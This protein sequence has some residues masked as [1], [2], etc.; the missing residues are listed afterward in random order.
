MTLA[1]RALLPPPWVSIW[2]GVPFFPMD[3][4]S[5]AVLA[6]GQILIPTTEALSRVFRFLIRVKMAVH[7]DS[8]SS[9]FAEGSGSKKPK[10]LDDL[11]PIL[12]IDEDEIAEM[13]LP[14]RKMKCQR[15]AS[16]GLRWQEYI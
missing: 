7:F 2:S 6:I 5:L 4:Q 9:N 1:I 8:C 3:I 11:L 10:A 15:R 16:S 14:R 13:N 12:G